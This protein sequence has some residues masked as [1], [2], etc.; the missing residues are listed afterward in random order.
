MSNTKASP[1]FAVL[2][3]SLTGLAIVFS[4]A[5]TGSPSESDAKPDAKVDCFP[6][7]CYPKTDAT[8][9]D[10][11]KDPTVFRYAKDGRCAE[12]R[13]SANLACNNLK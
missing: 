3:G 8:L 10:L 11:E 4:G 5:L 1:G 6:S 9:S 7:G 13:G 2:M 12:I